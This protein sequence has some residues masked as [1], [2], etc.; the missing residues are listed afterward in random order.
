MKKSIDLNLFNGN[1]AKNLFKNL[2]Y[3]VYALCHIDSKGDSIAFYI[4]KG[5]GDRCLQHLKEE[6]TSKA[7]KISKSSIEERFTIDILR[8]GLDEQTAKIVEA[9]CI[10]LVNVDGLENKVRGSGIILGRLPLEELYHLYSAQPI[11]IKT[12]HKGLLFILNK[13]YKSGMTELEL[14]EATC[15]V[16]RNIPRSSDIKYAY[17]SYHGI[18]KEVYSIDKWQDAGT[19]NYTSRN[20]DHRPDNFLDSRHEFVG[21]V[22]HSE[23]RD[24][25]KGKLVEFTRSYGSPF[26]KVGF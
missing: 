15:G 17:A 1:Q 14:Y 23:I 26:V 18:I 22:T 25:Y 12:E 3:Y 13:T 6:G 16:W 10:D 24:K 7:E 19:Y 2:K 21:N 4:G 8:H 5:V 9:T 20:F 11:E